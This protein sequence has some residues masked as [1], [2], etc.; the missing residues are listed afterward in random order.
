MLTG[1]TVVVA[2][3]LLLPG[4]GSVMTADTVA[5]LLSVLPVSAKATA[6][7]SV[8][9]ALPTANEGVEHETVPPEAGAGVVHDQ[10]PGEDSEANAVPAGSVSLQEAENAASGPLLVTVIV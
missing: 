1:S 2:V 6:T 4:V 8:K 5:V 3:A 10:P 7:L 9:A